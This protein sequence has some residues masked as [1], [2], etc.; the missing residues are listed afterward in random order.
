[1]GNLIVVLMSIFQWLGILS[2]FSLSLIFLV[3]IPVGVKCCFP[4]V[5]V[6]TAPRLRRLRVFSCAPCPFSCSFG[7][8]SIHILCTFLS[9]F[10]FFAHFLIAL[11]SHSLWN[12][13]SSMYTLHAACWFAAIFSHAVGWI[14]LA[15][16]CPLKKKSFQFW[17]WT[18][19]LFAVLLLLLLVLY[20]RDHSL[21]QLY[22][23]VMGSQLLE[24]HLPKRLFCPHL[25]TLV[26][27]SK[28]QSSPGCCSSGDWVR[29]A[30]L[31]VTGSIPSQSTGLGCGPGPQSG[32]CERQ[33]HIDVSLS[34]FLLPFPSL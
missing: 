8:M 7:E 21:V 23:F 29:A 3:C 14:S 1:M 31:R 2:I 28:N 20:L 16:G 25:I 34:L 30:N 9:F 13:K 6:G 33:P 24:H 5:V 27:L 12:C 19:D 17:W 22:S 15:R 26:P 18:I 11:S 10:F 32:A 4:G